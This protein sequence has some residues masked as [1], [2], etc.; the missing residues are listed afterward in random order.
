MRVFIALTLAGVTL[1]AGC[2]GL[3]DRVEI[4][5]EYPSYANVDELRTSAD[6]VVEV[7]VLEQS[8]LVVQ[9]LDLTFLESEDPRENFLLGLDEEAIEREIEQLR[10]GPPLVYTAFDVQVLRAYV[11]SVSPGDVLQVRQ[12]GGLH[13]RVMYVEEETSLLSPG[14]RYILFLSYHDEGIWSLLNPDQGQY[15]VGRDGRIEPL[16]GNPTVVDRSDLRTP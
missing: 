12:V 9:E 15:R 2:A 13:E 6:A 11:G 10:A 14:D 3:P 8:G 4:Y 16:E 1:S 7:E 5:S